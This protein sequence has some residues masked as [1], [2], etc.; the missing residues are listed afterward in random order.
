MPRNGIRRCYR[1]HE[2]IKGN[3]LHGKA[4]VSSANQVSTSFMV[5]ECGIGKQALIT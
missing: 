1:L 2:Y 3:R 5:G 4:K